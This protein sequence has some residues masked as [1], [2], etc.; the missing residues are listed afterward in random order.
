MERMTVLRTT[1]W[2]LAMFTIGICGRG[3]GIYSQVLKT[4][5]D[6]WMDIVQGTASAPEQYRV[7]VVLAAYWVAQHLQWRGHGPSLGMVFWGFDVTTGCAA[8]LLLYQLLVRSEAFQRASM[9]MQWFGSA[10]FAAVMFYLIDWANWYQR[11]ST[12]PTAMI[13]ALMVWLW[14]RR[15]DAVSTGLRVMSTAG[16]F[17]LLAIVQSFIRAD[18]ASMMCLGVFV[19]SLAGTSPKLSL[20]KG[21]ALAVAG[22]TAMMTLAI[23]YYLVKVRYPRASYGDVPVVMLTHEWRHPLNAVT[24]AI[25]LVPFLW[26][27]REAVRQRFWGEGAGGAIL[28]AS[29]GYACLWLVMGRMDEVRIFLP[30]AMAIT[31]LTIELA[32]RRLDGPGNVVGSAE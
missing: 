30:M 4:K 16:A 28:I 23:Q 20:P 22:V 12:L 17:F 24:A 3:Y 11:V 19:A 7:G 9:A 32:M 1:R 27:L 2:M 6:A 21:I 14:T 8:A 13:V 29:L 25:F 15:D 31:P 10:G 26:T 5:P 18:V